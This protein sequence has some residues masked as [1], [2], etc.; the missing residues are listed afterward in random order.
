MVC[1]RS[2]AI[3]TVLVTGGDFRTTS[4]E[5]SN[6]RSPLLSYMK[7]RASSFFTILTFCGQWS[8]IS[9]A[10]FRGCLRG[11]IFTCTAQRVGPRPATCEKIVP[12]RRGPP[13]GLNVS[14]HSALGAEAYDDVRRL[15]RTS[16]ELGKSGTTGLCA[17]SRARTAP[18]VIAR[19][20]AIAPPPTSHFLHF[21]GAQNH[22]VYIHQPLRGIS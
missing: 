21:D 8:S 13:G 10:K 22:R 7:P 2:A 11:V 1:V 15:W 20:T 6:N 12:C 4:R 5:N 14:Y 18:A 3:L 9:M 17:L 16:S 19:G